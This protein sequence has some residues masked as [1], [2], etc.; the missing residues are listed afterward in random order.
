MK[1]IILMLVLSIVPVWLN[2]QFNFPDVTLQNLDGTR[3]SSN[4]IIDSN[5]AV[6]MIF[7]KSYDTKS[8]NNLDNMQ[9]AWL[10][11]LKEKG[12]KMVG[13]CIDGRGSWSSVKPMINGRDWEFDN[14]IDN[15]GDFKRALG[16]T[17]APY[18]LLLNKNH[19][20]ICRYEG[21][22]TGNEDMV[23]EKIQNGLKEHENPIIPHEI[24]RK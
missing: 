9:S 17:D 23:C 15:N 3:V 1:T 7:W 13:I 2:A 21:Y 5:Q 19:E 8:C 16:V 11:Q 22:C 6:I 12:V 10:N 14:Y 4:K 24:A 18:T 20:E